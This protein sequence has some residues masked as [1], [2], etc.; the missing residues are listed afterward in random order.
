VQA[1]NLRP[2][3]GDDLLCRK[4]H[5][6]PVQRDRL[7]CEGD[8]RKLAG[9]KHRRQGRF[10]GRLRWGGR[11]LGSD[12]PERH[13]Y[14]IVGPT[15]IA[16]VMMPAALASPIDR[17]AIEL[18]CWA[19]ARAAARHYGK[20]VEEYERMLGPDGNVRQPSDKD[21]IQRGGRLW[22]LYRGLA[23]EIRRKVV[24]H[25]QGRERQRREA[26]PAVLAARHEQSWRA[27][28]C[29]TSVP[30]SRRGRQ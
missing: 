19:G 30:G 16:P 25:Q 4:D 21:V 28:C 9:L 7:R 17:D 8:A 29:P 11:A 18:Y 15:E 26:K 1:R 2:I 27:S 12:S 20:P 6:D 3:P 14:P 13:P 10:A 23:E 24:A 22:E 5:G